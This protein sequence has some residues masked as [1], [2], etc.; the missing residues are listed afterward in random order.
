[1]WYYNNEITGIGIQSTSEIN[2]FYKMDEDITFH[3]FNKD[4]IQVLIDPRTMKIIISE[5]P[6]E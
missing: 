4:P 2:A 1:M 5:V 3:L 6:V